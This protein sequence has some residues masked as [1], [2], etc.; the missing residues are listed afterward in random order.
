M[1][2]VA[3]LVFCVFVAACASSK[4]SNDVPSIV[5]PPQPVPPAAPPPDQ[6]I[7]ALETSMTEMLDRLDVIDERISQLENALPQQAPAAAAP[8]APA[9]NP[10]VNIPDSYKR[11]LILYGE[12][13]HDEA[14]AAFQKVFDAN[15][16]GM[17]ANNAL[18]WIGQTY[19]AAGDYAN[20]IRYY[21]RVIREYP[22]KNKA[23][24]AMF[25]LGLTY[26]K[27][28]DLA[29]AKQ[30]LEECIRRYPY[31]EAASS[32]RGELKRISY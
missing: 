29:M 30:T 25:K 16:S 1:R 14:R 2:R 18:F 6:R 23:P 20:A 4:N 22:D 21:Q 5:P 13:K 9:Q 15:P 26:V 31:S 32:A 7:D 8:S 11:A 10:S 12:G 28:G 24:D 27:T 19:Y 3:A 17:L